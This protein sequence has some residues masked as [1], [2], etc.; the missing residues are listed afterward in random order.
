[1]SKRKSHGNNLSQSTRPNSVEL[2]VYQSGDAVVHESRT[3][4]LSEGKIEILLDGLP[5]G[6]V[7]DSFEIDEVGGPGNFT[8]GPDCF[9]AADLSAQTLLQKSIGS[10]ITLLEQTQQELIPTTG[11]LRYVLNREVVLETDRGLVVMPMTAKFE[12]SAKLP[13]DVNSTPTLTQEASVDKA[14]DYNINSKYEVSGMEFSTSYRINYDDKTERVTELRCRVK[15]ANGTGADYTDAVVKLLAAD[16][17]SGSRGGGRMSSRSANIESRQ[18]MSVSAMAAPGAEPAQVR[19]VGET[20]LYE[21]PE[22]LSIKA[23]QTKRPYLYIARDIPVTAEL[24]LRQSAYYDEAR[25]DDRKLPVNVRLKLKNDKDHNLGM[26][27]PAGTAAVYQP[28]QNKDQSQGKYQKTDPGLSVPAVAEGEAFKLSLSTPSSDVKATRRL[29]RFHQDTDVITVEMV[30]ERLA[31]LGE[32]LKATGSQPLPSPLPGDP[33]KKKMPLFRE[34]ERVVT[35]YNYKERAVEVLV[36]EPL[37]GTEFELLH[38]SHDFVEQTLSQGT[39][40]VEV[41]AKDA[42]TIKYTIRWQTN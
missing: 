4:H 18:S 19:S 29:V 14:G 21:L 41:P 15:L 13:R 6:F 5:T 25:E 3:V 1:M 8:L 17:S 22:R 31:G 34:E 26:A 33:D 20:K 9:Q 2:A 27:L 38:K 10:K 42:I 30:N 36:H 28:E 23:G 37:P 16:N 35:I 40:K 12:L 32:T 39:Y 11:T 7:E 24:Y